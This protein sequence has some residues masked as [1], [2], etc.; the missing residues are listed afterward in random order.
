MNT[1]FRICVMFILLMLTFSLVI[2]FLSSTG[3]FPHTTGGVSGID[4][5]EDAL[6][7]FTG[8]SDPTMSAIFLGVT[9][10]AFIAAVALAYLTK[11]II[12]IGL[13]LFGTI[14]WASWVSMLSIFSFGGYMPGDLLL[15][16]TVGVMFVFI[17][18]VVGILTGSG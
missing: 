13:H 3:A 15:I 16:F 17:A 6:S 2:N 18:A 1:F 8:L 14:F 5:P 7:V 9:G 12:P 4:E 11:S 10:L